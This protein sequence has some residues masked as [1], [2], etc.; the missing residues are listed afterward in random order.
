MYKKL[1]INISFDYVLRY[2]VRLYISFIGDKIRQSYPFFHAVWLCSM[3]IPCLTSDSSKKT[4]T[5]LGYTNNGTVGA[6]L[7]LATFDS[8]F[9]CHY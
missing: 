8:I 7:K 6:T 4:G 9:N 1:E 5:L 2:P 3:F